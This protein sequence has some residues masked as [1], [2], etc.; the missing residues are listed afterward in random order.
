MLNKDN[1]FRLPYP[2]GCNEDEFKYL[3]FLQDIVCGVLEFQEGVE[4]NQ[5]L[6]LSSTGLFQSAFSSPIYFTF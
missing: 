1:N 6:Q 2:H 4:G 5:C 3:L